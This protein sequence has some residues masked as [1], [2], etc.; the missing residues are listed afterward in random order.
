MTDAMTNHSDMESLAAFVDG[1]LEREERDA[2]VK[3]LETCEECQGLV[4]E[5][6]AFEQEEEAA[7]A[8]PKPRRTWWAAAAAVSIV[9]L[10]SALFVPGYQHRR[11]L[12]QERQELFSAL[13]KTG[14]TTEARFSGQDEYAKVRPT[15]RNAGDRKSLDEHQVEGAAADLAAASADRH[16][17]AD[18]QAA[19]LA[20]A[21][22]RNTKKSREDKAREAL[23]ILNSIPL[24][25]RSAAIWNDIATLNYDLGSLDEAKTAVDEALRN[26]RKM[27]EA[28]FNRALILQSALI[29][30][31]KGD[32]K[33]AREA[34]VQYVAV[35]KRS[36]WADEAP[37]NLQRLS[38]FSRNP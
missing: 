24:G 38:D 30:Q 20:A 33:A 35:D 2:V 26:E 32:R 17:P 13:V 3:H 1:R 22:D 10:S 8:A 14:R 21:F 9:V 25:E 11:E 31:R 5:A 37:K 6:A 4:R 16:S 23:A 29:L 27:P 12:K 28:L 19:A 7:A 34:W 18:L 15:F 36:R